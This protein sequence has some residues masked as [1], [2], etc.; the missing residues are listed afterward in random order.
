MSA[1][2]VIVGGGHAGGQAVASLRQGGFDGDITLVTAEQSLPYQ[3]PPLSKAYLAGE[4]PRER[5]LMRPSAFYE[6][7]GVDVRLGIEV[8]GLDAGRRSLTLSD[9][10]QLTYDH[11][12][13]ATGGRPRPLPCPGADHPA[14]HYLRTIADVD[15]MRPRFV[16]GACIVIVGA[17]YIGLEV[18]AVAIKHGLRPV[19]LEM[20]PMVLARVA[21]P[22]V[23]GF[24]ENVHRGA[25]VDLRTGVAAS[26]I[27][28]RDGK[29]VVVSTAGDRI[30]ADLVVAGVG[31][32]P[33]VELAQAA[34]STR[35]AG[36]RH[37]GSMRSATAATIRAACTVGACVLN[38][39]TT[40]WSR[41]KRRRLTSAVNRWRTTRC[42]GSG[43]I[44]TSSSCRQ[45]V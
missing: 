5:L 16:P 22:E 29:A 41:P 19:V 23:A 39:C 36:R 31:L 9:G 28:D 25:G 45:P 13:L 20:A 7:A 6:G 33:N 11:M 10:G 18:A 1:N 4:L 42:R 35:S 14:V 44:S 30:E 34:G 21:S 15:A 3:R 43:P 12:I 27:E 24:F 8:T 2:V 26:A 37:R 32:L 17:G 38:P 40:L